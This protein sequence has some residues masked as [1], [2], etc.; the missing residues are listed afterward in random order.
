MLEER[1][2]QSEG[3]PKRSVGKKSPGKKKVKILAEE[4]ILGMGVDP[5]DQKA[6][7]RQILGGAQG[8]WPFTPE[9]CDCQQPHSKSSNFCPGFS[10]YQSSP[11][12]EEKSRL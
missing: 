5:G 9:A 1:G 8:L 12:G 11:C 4:K 10:D 7:W 6:A 3:F 2:G